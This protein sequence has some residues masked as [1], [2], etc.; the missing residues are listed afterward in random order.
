MTQAELQRD[1][2]LLAAALAEGGVALDA[3]QESHPCLFSRERVH[4]RA[5]EATRMADLVGAVESVL[6]LPVWRERVL[7]DAPEIARHPVTARGVFFGYDFHLSPTLGPQLIEINTNAGGGALA[8]ALERAWPD[9]TAPDW[10]AMFAEEWALSGIARPLV[11]VAIVDAQPAGQY[12][13]P[14]FCLFQSM[15]R[16]V[17]IDAVLADPAELH[18]DG[19]VLC[20]QGQR[21]DLVYNRLTDFQLEQGTS[22]ALRQA[23]LADAVVVTPHPQAHAIYADKRNL[24]ALSD[25]SVLAELGVPA[26]T[27]A[28]LL[29]RIPATRRVVRADADTLWQARRSLFFKPAAGFGS[30]AAYRG[31]KLTKRVFEDILA[32]EYIAQAIVP[33]SEVA[34]AGGPPEAAPRMKLDLRNYVYNGRIQLRVA[35][36]Y[37]GQTTN[38]RT[39]GGG[40]APVVVGAKGE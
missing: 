16:A 25:A 11:R 26:S 21:I 40:F 34:V 1:D 23:Y 13:Y 27:Q 2:R 15:F 33:P 4:L 30:R 3:L 12:L 17:G 10:L 32:G 35:R 19:Q 14:E 7:A 18:W 36:L 29:A 9:A 37:Q 38:F 22:Q 39:P 8:A 31:D 6:A 5:D 28:I 24:I 20:H